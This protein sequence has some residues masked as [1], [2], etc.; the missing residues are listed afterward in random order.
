MRLS[1]KLVRSLRNPLLRALLPTTRTVARARLELSWMRAELNQ[2]RLAIACLARGRGVPLQYL[3][4]TQPFG[5]LDIITEP[6]TLIARWETEEWTLDLAR[7]VACLGTSVRVVDLCTGTGCILFALAAVAGVS[8]VGVDIS[9]FAERTFMKNQKKFRLPN[10]EFMR[11][12]IF[13]PLPIAGKVDL[14][15]ANPPYI[16]PNELARAE[17]SVLLYEPRIALVG[18]LRTYKALLARV[19]ELQPRAAAFEV[20][21]TKQAKFLQT[22]FEALGYEAV[23]RFDG[24]GNTRSVFAW[25]CVEWAFMGKR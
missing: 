19:S 2:R 22:E 21:D 6:G 10:L 4:G 23:M 18:G 17:P 14:V 15:T 5:P 1:P 11:S 25:N 12:D 20:N 3:L 8:G 24:R 13:K 9:P 7:S 16:P